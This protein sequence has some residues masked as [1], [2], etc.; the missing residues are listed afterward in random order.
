MAITCF[1]KKNFFGN[2][3]SFI[4]LKDFYFYHDNWFTVFC[5]FST[6]RQSDPVTQTYIHYFSHIILHHAPLQ[7]TRYSSPNI[8]RFMNLRVILV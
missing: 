4:S 1:L 8:E 6:V 5:E 7:V 2:Q 3:K